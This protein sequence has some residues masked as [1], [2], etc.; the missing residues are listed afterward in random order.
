[1]MA[2]AAMILSAC[3]ENDAVLRD[4][5][6]FEPDYVSTEA[7]ALDAE[8]VQINVAMRGARD[9]QDVADFADCV[10]SGY[11]DARGFGFA[12]HL[13]TQVT[14]E[15]GLWRG[16]A[17]YTISPGMPAGN[18]TIDIEAQREACAAN[19]IPQLVR[20]NG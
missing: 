18:R 11:A 15:S 19:G 17:V 6:P 3:T 7:T 5:L 10:I 2:G 16:D 1:M 8:L 20:T 12:R 9:G 13:R 14:E 4:E